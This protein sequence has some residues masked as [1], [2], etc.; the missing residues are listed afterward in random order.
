M[1]SSYAELRRSSQRILET[2][3]DDLRAAIAA[4][5]DA[6]ERPAWVRSSAE[7]LERL[8][9]TPPT[10]SNVD[11]SAETIVQR[12]GRPVLTIAGGEAELRFEDLAGEVWRNRLAGSSS[13]LAPIIA[14]VGRIEVVNHPFY[15]YV[16]TGWLVADDLVV[17]NRHV[18]LEF[19]ERVASGWK[20]Q[21]GFDRRSAI[22][23]RID[24][25]EEIGNELAAEIP[26]SEVWWI[27]PDDGP[28]VAFLKLQGASLGSRP[29]PVPLAAS[30]AAA[31]TVVAT[32]G[33]P[34]RDSRIPE[35]DLMDQI[36]GGVYDKKRLAPGFVTGLEG[37][38][39][40]HDCTTL[41]GNSG[42]VVVDL[43]RGEA[44]G[45]H[46][47]GTFLRANYAVASPAL[48]TLLREARERPAPAIATA[49]A[50]AAKQDGATPSA[51]PQGLVARADGGTLRL[52]VPVEIQVSIGGLSGSPVISS[53]AAPPHATGSHARPTR[54]Q[55][56]AAAEH[57]RRE[58]ANRADVVSIEAGWRFRDGWITDE[59]AVVIAVRRKLSAE[60]LAAAGRT[61]IP[62][63]FDGV[64]VD[65]TIAS[66]EGL[67]SR[68]AGLGLEAPSWKA[69]YRLRPDLPLREVDEPMKVTVHV[70]PDAGWPELEK[71]LGRTTRRL[72]IGMYDFGAPH[73][74]EAVKAAVPG[75]KPLKLVLQAGE[76]LNGGTKRDDLAD[77]AVVQE[78]RD[79][80]TS[81]FDFAW[82]S[83][84]G[85]DRLFH[86]SYH[87]K[88]AVR[89]GKELWLSSG[90]W[91]SSNQPALDPIDGEDDS[92]PALRKYNREWH[93]I[94][95][96][97]GLAELFEKHLERDREEAAAQAADESPSEPELWVP[98]DYFRPT[99][100]ELEAP[101][102]YQRPLTVDRRVRLKP[103]LSP[104]NYAE[105]VLELLELARERIYFQNQ[106]LS[107]LAENDPKYEALL[108][109]LKEKQRAG[110][111]V[112]ILFRRFGDMREAVSRIKDFGFDTDFVRLQTNCHT[113]GIVVDGERV[114]VGSHNWTN[115][116]AVYNRDASLI[117]FDEEIARYFERLF[118]YDWSRSGRPNIDESVPAVEWVTADEAAPRPGY[119]RIPASRW[120][121]GG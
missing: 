63:S 70:S 95:E 60:E 45:L 121:Q 37:G 91:Q 58:L 33:Y 111:E 107:I 44:V 10:E 19:A 110:V 17:T 6:K 48:G 12:V 16:G 68:S 25:L 85:P 49:G 1:K 77:A 35:R 119:V 88:V 31:R 102:R 104:D 79:A 62:S 112:R 65:V 81:R 108:T 72:T 99:A 13:T 32:I 96:N 97:D 24:F 30:A 87:I 118:L 114:L 100:A 55:A 52:T 83:V 21:L 61:P 43:A 115:A 103:L 15:D 67:R 18:A 66:A 47:A 105:E 4:L 36:F 89:D 57:A 69:N 78:L 120:F 51:T 28:D 74:L 94:V 90:N 14:S 27:A 73:I 22:G 41:G 71:F 11:F 93:A 76:S 9:E 40:T 82:A 38:A 64:A 101:V 53:G 117:F 113:K 5:R 54:G 7:A 84:K 59:R 86:N 20:F 75:A 39:L 3:D 23:A 46:F 98:L 29:R 26:I 42:S 2:A 116:G 80:K 106:S 109:A 8:T 34:A 92:P 50:A 56:E